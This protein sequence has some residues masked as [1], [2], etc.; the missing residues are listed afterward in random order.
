[1]N[2]TKEYFIQEKNDISGRIVAL[3]DFLNCRGSFDRFG[4]YQHNLMEKQLEA[5]EDYLSALSER[6]FYIDAIT[7]IETKV[8]F[9]VESAKAALKYT[10][11]HQDNAKSTSDIFLNGVNW[12]VKYL[13]ANGKLLKSRKQIVNDAINAL[14][15]NNA[16]VLYFD[17]E[18]H[19]YI[20]YWYDEKTDS[21]AT[22]YTSISLAQF[23]DEEF[24]PDLIDT[25]LSKL[26]QRLIKH[27]K[28]AK[29]IELKLFE[30]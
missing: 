5:M 29:G 16:S 26:E 22:E 17:S 24:N 20:H 18:E 15:G 13:N 6:L 27:F 11:E 2:N 19:G 14:N 7:D 8:D 23:K 30:D 1:M 12:A 25:T 3:K 9:N 21:L 28:D 10:D 4:T